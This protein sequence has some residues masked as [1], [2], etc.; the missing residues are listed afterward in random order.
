M[1]VPPLLLILLAPA[2]GVVLIAAIPEQR[3]AWVRR[4]AA[5]STLISLLGAL[6][7]ACT[8]HIGGTSY[9]YEVM[10]PW[11][12]TLG[13]GFHLGVDGISTALMLLHAVCAFTGVLVSYAIPSRVKEY[14]IF[15]LVLITGVFGVFLSLDLFFFYFF[16]EMAVLPMYPLIGIWGSDVKEHGVVRFSKEYAAMKDRKSV[17]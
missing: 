6:S 14:Y 15:Y 7:I 11:V 12:P 16:Y 3:H 4:I 1:P 8:Y 13:I 5:G 10:I 9:Q 17:V 2:L